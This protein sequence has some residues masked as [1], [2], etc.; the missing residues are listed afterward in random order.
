MLNITNNQVDVNQNHNEISPRTV[1]T[2]KI[3]NVKCWRLC[4][5][6][7]NSCTAGGNLTWYNYCEKQYGSSS[8]S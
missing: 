3:R 7:G 1:M 5:E 2:K 6:K 8:E 4:S